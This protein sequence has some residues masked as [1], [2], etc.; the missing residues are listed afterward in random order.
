MDKKAQNIIVS[1]G[2]ADDVYNVSVHNT[3][4]R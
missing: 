1:Y 2:N 3:L 4:L